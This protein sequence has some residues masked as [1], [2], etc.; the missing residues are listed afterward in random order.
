MTS[1]KESINAVYVKITEQIDLKT[2]SK[3]DLLKTLDEIKEQ[4]L[5]NEKFISLMKKLLAGVPLETEEE[6]IE[7][8]SK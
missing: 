6:E 2:G 7:A 1:I 8:N 5:E 3:E 4:E